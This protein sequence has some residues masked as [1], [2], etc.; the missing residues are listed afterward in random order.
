MRYTHDCLMSHFDGIVRL[1]PLLVCVCVCVCVRV[2]VR[3]GVA[4]VY[5]EINKC[6][7]SVFLEID[8]IEKERK[9]APPIAPSF[10]ALTS[11]NHARPS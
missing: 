3:S 9:H 10:A 8:E 1:W 6:V 4:L 2:C 5:Q 7:T 11:R